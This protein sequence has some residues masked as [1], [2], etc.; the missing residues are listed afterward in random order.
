[1]GELAGKTLLITGAAK[2]IGRAAAEAARHEGA[3]VIGADVDEALL[4]ATAAELGLDPL[5]LDVT[6]PEMWQAAE[7]SVR[8]R[9]GRLDALVNNAG[10]ILHR[11]FLETSLEDFRRIQ[12]IN[13]EGV[14][15][16]M[17]TFFPLLSETAKD[18][19]GSSIVNLSS[20]YG[21]VGAPSQAAYCASKGAV[22][23]MTK[24]VALEFGTAG[25]RVRVNSVH[26]GPVNTDLIRDLWKA[27]LERGL[28]KS[29]DEAAAGYAAQQ[30][31]GRI[32]EADDIVGAI[33]F[34]ASDRSRFMT[35][36][37]MVIDGGVTAR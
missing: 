23:L 1:M 7:A 21:I 13:V 36:A 5:L 32:A 31:L 4:N 24:A 33:I 16:G 8:A 28:I 10:V 11:P 15:L 25:T 3:T 26:P 37:E 27:G 9:H 14:W 30:P 17:Q 6:S 18:T 12:A 2:G 22:R 20:I 29:V 19:E 34:L 35:G